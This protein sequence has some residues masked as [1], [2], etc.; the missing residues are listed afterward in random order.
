MRRPRCLWTAWPR[1]R[2]PPSVQ[3][4]NIQLLSTAAVPR[5]GRDRRAGRG[6]LTASSVWRNNNSP[7]ELCPRRGSG[8][9]TR[10][11]A[12]WG[13]VGGTAGC[14]ACCRPCVTWALHA[15][16]WEGHGHTLIS[17]QFREGSSIPERGSLSPRFVI[18]RLH[19][20]QPGSVRN[21]TWGPQLP[22]SSS[23]PCAHHWRSTFLL[24][25]G[26]PWAF[27]SPCPRCGAQ[28]DPFT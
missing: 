11:E 21:H 22:Q 26:G 10:P 5:N 14:L 19:K 8:C 16:G 28:S 6:S 17:I 3:G 9:G 25:P 1:P 23:R 4:R 13:P 12:Q 24:H 2:A 27:P 15:K 7:V 18:A 20:L